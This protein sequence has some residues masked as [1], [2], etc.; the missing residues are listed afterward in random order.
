MC[1]L[2]DKDRHCKKGGKGV[3][4][5]FR[6]ARTVTSP[7]LVYKVLKNDDGET[8]ISPYRGFRWTFGEEHTATFTHEVVEYFN[9]HSIDA[10]LHAFRDIDSAKHLK[11]LVVGHKVYYGVIPVGAKVYMGVGNDIVA[12]RMTVYASMNDLKAVHGKV[13]TTPIHY[14]KL[15]KGS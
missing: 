4:P 2:V 3:N 1:L 9:E 8:A 13:C 10:G 15:T 12:T 6:R 5:H 7:I 14:R 11:N